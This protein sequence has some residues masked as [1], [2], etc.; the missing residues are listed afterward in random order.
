VFINVMPKTGVAPNKQNLNLNTHG[1]QE[2]F[3]NIKLEA[4]HTGEASQISHQS[5][6]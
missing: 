2:A 1:T 4:K 3:I 5:N 6:M